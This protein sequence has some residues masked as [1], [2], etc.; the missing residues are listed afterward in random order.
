MWQK[1]GKQMAVA[2]SWPLLWAAQLATDAQLKAKVQVRNLEK[3]R[4][5]GGSVGSASDFGSGHGLAVCELESR[6]GLCADS[7][8]PGACF[9][10]CVSLSLSLPLPS[11]CLQIAHLSSCLL[12]FFL[13]FIFDRDRAR[14]GKGQR[15]RE[16]DTESEAGC[17]LRADTEPVGLELTNLEITT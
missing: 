7:L 10:F 1:Q 13:M 11:S 8:E 4:C 15:E 17:R 2:V 14:A 6:V 9:R 16:G 5:L 3:Q 12:L